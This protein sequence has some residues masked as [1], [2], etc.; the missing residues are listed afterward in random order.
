MVRTATTVA[1]MTIMSRSWE[2]SHHQA[3]SQYSYVPIHHS[4]LQCQFR[5][6][7][8][9][10]HC[11]DHLPKYRDAET[12][13]L[14]GKSIEVKSVTDTST[15]AAS[16]RSW[17]TPMITSV[18]LSATLNAMRCANLVKRAQQWQWGSLWIR[19]FGEAACTAS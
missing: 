3:V 17:S 11:Q 16:S 7:H 12:G 13:T 18:R 6:F 8:P 15:K 4:S 19:E 10:Y 14:V 5:N 2:D 1:K 9:T